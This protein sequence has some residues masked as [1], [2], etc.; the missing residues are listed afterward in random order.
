MGVGHSD[1]HSEKPCVHLA[2]LTDDTEDLDMLSLSVPHEASP[3][4]VGR[5]HHQSWPGGE[6]NDCDRMD[7]VSSA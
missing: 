6:R 1:T 3:V 7:E 4:T 5:W 2:V